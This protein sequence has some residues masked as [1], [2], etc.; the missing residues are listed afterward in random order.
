MPVRF[1]WFEDKDNLEMLNLA[2]G[3][4]FYVGMWNGYEYSGR[5]L[6][7]FNHTVR[8]FTGNW[9]IFEFEFKQ[10]Q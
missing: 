10:C 8:L 6:N 9:Y 1:C 3:G 5:V 2:L 7:K 4:T